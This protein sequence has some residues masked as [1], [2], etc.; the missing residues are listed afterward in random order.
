LIQD[1]ALIQ[2]LV[3][4]S[5]FDRTHPLLA[6]VALVPD[7]HMKPLLVVMHGYGGGR[8]AVT[9]DIRELARRGVVAL[10]P[11]MRGRGGSAGRWD[12]GGLDVHDI[13]DAVLAALVRY[14]DEIDARNLSIVGYSGGGG[15][16]IACMVRFP[17]LFQ[18]YVSFFGI[19][20]YGGWHRSGGRPDCNA[21]MEVALGG[22]PDDVPALYAARNAIPAAGNARCGKL[23]F[24]WDEEE[25]MCPPEMIEAFLDV[26]HEAGLVNA[27]VHVSHRGDM[28]R[29]SHNYRSGNPDLSAADDLYLGDVF[30]SKARSPRL[31]PRGQ[32][33][34]PGYLVTRQFQV[35]IEDGQRGQVTV[36]YDLTGSA[37]AVRVVDNAQGY[38]VRIL[39]GSPLSRLP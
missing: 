33:V 18:T 31:P 8:E 12:S 27:A 29:W 15:N 23:H 20:D 11:D 13:L 21:W 39:L 14:P 17:D 2:E 3:Y 9:Q 28:R 7:G 38:N 35:W 36:D 26:H 19:S 4:A 37:P 25:T 6:D 5:S 32:L 16:A 34:V 10:A 22:T 24:L 1:T 30:P